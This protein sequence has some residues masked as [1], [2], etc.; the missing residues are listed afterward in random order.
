MLLFLYGAISNIY[1]QIS[2]QQSANGFLNS[3]IHNDGLTPLNDSDYASRISEEKKGIR[4]FLSP[5]DYRGTPYFSVRVDSK[6]SVVEL[7]HPFLPEMTDGEVQ[8]VADLI[9]AD[10]KNFGI[11]KMISYKVYNE[12][13]G[14]RMIVAFDRTREQE[15]GR[16]HIIVFLM[17]TFFAAAVL[18]AVGYMLSRFITSPVQN[19]FIKQQD[20]IA[21]ASH[22]LKTPISVIAANVSV[23]ENE[24][25][26]NKWLGYIKSECQRMN[27]L[28]QDM[29]FLAK[30]D[31]GRYELSVTGFDIANAVSCAVLPFESVAF[32]DRKTLV[33]EVPPEP[34]MVE[35]DEDKIK[36][37][38]V[39]LTDNAIKNSYENTEIKVSLSQ[40][41]DRV[42]VSVYNSGY[43]I[44]K[45]DIN[46]IFD[47]FFRGDKS[48]ARK[49]GGY[50][51]GL[52]IAYAISKELGGSLT[53]KS[54]EQKYAQFTL[55]VPRVYRK[56]RQ[57]FMH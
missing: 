3:L 2:M 38:A 9:L 37:V 21:D 19:E 5:V 56:K 50:G 34:V 17:I 52:A 51:L 14:Q 11:V 45:D 49:T 35:S 54:E 13:S 48:R 24:L 32:E 33:L 1:F 55:E 4:Y 57:S 6:G 8:A 39:I 31:A 16:W 7:I 23:L 22:E 47:R 25:P 27:T 18:A 46:N 42:S 15:F 41:K 20:F 12:E 10:K 53:V 36:Q 29:L 28:V 30:D 26:D 44:S 40:S 43:G